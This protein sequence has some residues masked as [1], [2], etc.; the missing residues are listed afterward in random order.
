LIWLAVIKAPMYHKVREVPIELIIKSL[1][2]PRRSM[3]K[4]RDMIVAM[5]LTVAYIPVHLMKNFPS[6]NVIS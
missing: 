4:E 6:Q 3:K 2:R 5:S 1:R